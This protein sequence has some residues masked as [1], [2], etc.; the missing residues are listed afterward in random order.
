MSEA[1]PVKPQVSCQDPITIPDLTVPID[2]LAESLSAGASAAELLT[3]VEA[4]DSQMGE[5]GFTFELAVLVMGLL[6]PYVEEEAD[7]ELGAA[8]DALLFHLGRVQ[9]EHGE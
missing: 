6:R 8:L 5:W 2:D 4:I 3:L 9:G 7:T 1:E